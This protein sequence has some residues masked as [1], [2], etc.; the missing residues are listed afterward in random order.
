MR[1]L[2]EH[3]RQLQR[4]REAMAEGEEGEAIPCTP[5]LMEQIGREADEMDRRGEQPHPDACP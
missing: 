4:L 1:L 2:D 3:D 5:E